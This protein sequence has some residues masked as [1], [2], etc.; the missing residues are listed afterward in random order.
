MLGWETAT[1][2]S[3]VKIYAVRRIHQWHVPLA[4][5]IHSMTSEKH[6]IVVASSMTYIPLHS[7][8]T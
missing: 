8:T 7:S 5:W 6:I 1:L 3:T 4:S 2:E